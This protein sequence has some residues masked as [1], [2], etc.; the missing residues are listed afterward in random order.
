MRRRV[1]RRERKKQKKILIIGSL[2]LLLFLCVGYAAFST[3]LSITAKGNIKSKKASELLKENVVDTGDGLYKD[4]YEEGRYVYKGTNPDNYITFNNET[5]RIIALENDGTIQII[6]NDTLGEMMWA[7]AC[8]TLTYNTPK[9]KQG[10]EWKIDNIIYLAGG[11]N[12]CSVVWSQAS[13]Q[14]YLNGDY[15]ATITTN[16]DKIISHTWGIGSIIQI[17]NNDLSGQIDEENSDTWVGDIGLIKVSDYLRANNNMEQCGSLKLNNTNLEICK[18]TNWLYKNYDWWVLNHHDAADRIYYIAQQGYATYEN[19][20]GFS[21]GIVENVTPSLYLSS[22]ITL[23]GQ[24][25]EN[26]PYRITD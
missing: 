15:F 18:A 6:L 10:R 2:S 22:N 23:S 8:S 3:N 19:V 12:N 4:I 20:M 24:G 1:G 26:N 16:Q 5:W 21:I 25:T 17:D 14:Q 13:L 7:D 11:N 9:N